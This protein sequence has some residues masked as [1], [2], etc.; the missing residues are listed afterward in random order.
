MKEE[1]GEAVGGPLRPD[2]KKRAGKPTNF[3]GKKQITGSSRG[4]GPKS[5]VLRLS[6]IPFGFFE[7]ELDAYFKQFGNV[8]RVR[9]LRNKKVVEKIEANRF[10]LNCK[11]IRKIYKIN[12]KGNLNQT[13]I[14]LN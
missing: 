8:V 7:K 3:A 4:E 9:V 13:G 12:K 10:N 2:G 14:K 1:G 6:H 11:L 5:A